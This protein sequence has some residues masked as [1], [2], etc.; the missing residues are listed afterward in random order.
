MVVTMKAFCTIS[1]RNFLHLGLAMY[2]SLKKH[3]NNTPFSLYYLALDQFTF[4]FLKNQSSSFP[5]IVPIHI[6]EMSKDCLEIQLSRHQAPSI[7]AYN[8]A[9]ATGKKPEDIQFI[10]SL[11]PLF[12]WYVLSQN[13][14]SEILYVD[15]DCYF[16]NDWNKVFNAT[17]LNDKSIGLVR[18]RI[19]YNPAVG[20]YNV[21]IVYFKNDTPGY[22]AASSWKNWVTG[23]DTT[24]HKEFGICGD[25]K[26]LEL[27]VI[28]WSND[29]CV[30]DDVNIEH[31][32]PWNYPY[33][34]FTKDISYWHFSNFKP[35]YDKKQYQPAPR[36]NLGNIEGIVKMMYDEY[37]RE[38]SFWHQQIK[39]AV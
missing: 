18:H 22:T 12:T 38:T 4:D 30:L 1:D 5:E 33:N 10:W 7:E 16:F 37:Y 34:S 29:V 19:P 14:V 11:T 25:Q 24:F 13:K 17:S 28:L 3:S 9:N 39:Q 20:E 6:D 8:V 23:L 27:F 2:A 31:G 26:Y 21:G 36:H 15:A 35:D 32:A